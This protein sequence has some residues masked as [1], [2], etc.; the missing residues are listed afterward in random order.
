MD[1]VRPGSGV[2]RIED[3]NRLSSL[4]L[5]VVMGSLCLGIFLFGLDI[6]IIGVAIPSITTEFGSLSDI[7]WYGS[8][9]MLTITAFQ[10]LFGNLYKFFNTKVIY[11]ISL[12]I[13]EVGSAICAAAPTSPVLIFGRAFLGLG[14]AG[15]LQ[16]ALAIITDV[17]KL[18]QVPLFQG[19]VTSS[20][21]VSSTLGPVIGGALTQF[22]SWRWCFWINIPAG[23]A[24]ILVVLLFVPLHSSLKEYGDISLSTKLQHMDAVGLILFLGSI[25]SIL[26]VLTWAGQLYS[27]HDQRI[28]GLLVGFGILTSLLIYWLVPYMVAGGVICS[29]G[30]GLLTTVGLSTPTTEWAAYLVLTGIGIGMGVQVPYTA[31]QA[32]LEPADVAIG[33]AV[34]V[35][36]F[37]LA[38]AIGTAIG[39]N[40]LISGLYT[41]VPRYTDAVSASDVIQAGATGLT[42]VATSAVVL[43]AIR[44]AYVEA[45]CRTLILALAGAVLTVPASCGMEWINIKQVATER[46]RKQPTKDTVEDKTIKTMPEK[47][48]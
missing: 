4:R 34:F 41:A 9:Y 25:A 42:S 36:A 20:L 17:V 33:N 12:V 19:V 23:A 24:V 32:A 16:G 26:L 21:V 31:L 1:E 13:F 48:A 14:A 35:F 3:T 29:V 8:A 37:H 18:E 11:L 15:I 6:N 30:A 45:V 27:W 46:L 2:T 10:P 7:A 28:I 39:Q 40:L 22:V 47:L 5:G 38:G 43:D 44:V